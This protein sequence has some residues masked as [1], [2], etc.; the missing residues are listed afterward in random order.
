[1]RP[2]NFNVYTTPHVCVFTVFVYGVYMCI[3]RERERE[4][5]RDRC[6]LGCLDVLVSNISLSTGCEVPCGVR[7]N[8][9]TKRSYGEDQGAMDE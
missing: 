6:P 2:H 3:Y 9:E 5:E 7:Q 4:R 8:V 1:M